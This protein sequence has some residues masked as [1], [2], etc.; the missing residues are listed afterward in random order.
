MQISVSVIPPQ[1]KSIHWPLPNPAQAKGTHEQKMIV[2]RQ[3]R[4]ETKNVLPN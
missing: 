3:T 2:F 1:A 4:D